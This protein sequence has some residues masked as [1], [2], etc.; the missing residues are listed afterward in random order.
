MRRTI[1]LTSVMVMLLAVA[2][3][4]A[5]HRGHLRGPDPAMWLSD[6]DG[7]DGDSGIE[8]FDPVDGARGF[9]VVGR[10]AAR[11]A[12]RTTGLEPRHTYT[13]WIVYFNDA[14]RC[15]GDEGC[16]GEDFDRAGAGVVYGSG[17]IARHDGTARFVTRL[18]A[19]TGADV[20]GNTP[21]PPFATAAY[22]P[23]PHNEFHVVLRSHGPIIPGELFD[24]L[25]T[26]NGGCEVQVGPLP[27]QVGDFPVPMKAGECGDI[28][29]HVFS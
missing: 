27:E 12:L 13:M 16:N 8:Q 5:A 29:L 4:A 15:E 9:A 17:R 21:P 24:Q 20:V 6:P 22:E 2:A 25:T 18:R 28:Q 23:G 19:G 26:F 10:R 14:T 7:V 11:I 3:P 1:V